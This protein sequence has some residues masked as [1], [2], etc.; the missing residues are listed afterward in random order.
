MFKRTFLSCISALALLSL[1]GCASVFSSSTQV[2]E[3]ET[4]PED[5]S[6]TITNRSGEV[7]YQGRTPF[8]EELKKAK[9]FFK[10]EDY[11]VHIE[12]GGFRAVDLVITSHNNGWYVFGNTLN[13]FLPGWLIADP[14][15]TWFLIAQKELIEIYGESS[16]EQGT[17]YCQSPLPNGLCSFS[18]KDR[19]Y[20]A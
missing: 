1:G 9:G 6:I 20:R 17:H 8:K 5:A 18:Q 7:V 11:A 2:I 12:K 16:N 19:D 14:K 4:N 3:I 15:T 10:G 13:V